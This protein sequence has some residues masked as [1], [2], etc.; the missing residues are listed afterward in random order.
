MNFPQ[1]F[2][3]VLLAGG[4]SSRMGRDKA[5]I[6]VEGKPLWRRQFWKLMEI[7]A[8][9]VLISGR[10]DGPY[11]NSGGRIVPDRSLG[12]GP[13]AGI[14][15]ALQAISTDWLVVLAVD[16]VNIRSDFLR[17]LVG[18]ATAAG[19]GLVPTSADWFQ[20]LAAIYPRD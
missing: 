12:I 9:E 20:P 10:A 4:Q 16:L 7:G 2:S 11:R 1:P 19:V 15:A 5:E 17:R 6:L 18:E 3:A 8:K 14:D 13:L